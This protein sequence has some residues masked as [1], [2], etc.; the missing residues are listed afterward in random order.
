MKHMSFKKD[1]AALIQHYSLEGGSHTPAFLFA[2]YLV[3]CLASF[4]VTIAQ[5]TE[6]YRSLPA[7]QACK[8][9]DAIATVQG[10]QLSGEPQG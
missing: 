7:T 2:D 8:L 9:A 1:L 5:R 6:W 4:D 10:S 3:Q